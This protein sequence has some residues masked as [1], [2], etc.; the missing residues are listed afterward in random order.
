MI[1][2]TEQQELYSEEL[3]KHHSNL[4][5]ILEGHLLFKLLF[6]FPTNLINE[7]TGIYILTS[8]KFNRRDLDIAF[9][10]YSAKPEYYNDTTY[11][12]KIIEKFPESETVIDESKS[13]N[14]TD[15]IRRTKIKFVTEKEYIKDFGNFLAASDEQILIFTPFIKDEINNLLPKLK[16]KKIIFISDYQI[17]RTSSNKR[18]KI[19]DTNRYLKIKKNLKQMN[20]KIQVSPL[21]LIQARNFRVPDF[22]ENFKG[23]LIEKL[24][25]I[26]EENKT[27][28]HFFGEERY[29]AIRTIN[30]L[31]RSNLPL[32]YDL[33]RGVPQVVTPTSSVVLNNF[34]SLKDPIK[35]KDLYLRVKKISESLYIILNGL[36]KNYVEYFNHYEE[37]PLPERKDFREYISSIFI[38]LLLEK[39]KYN[40][41]NYKLFILIDQNLLDIVMPDSIDLETLDLITKNMI[42]VTE[43]ELLH[44]ADFWYA[45]EEDILSMN[46]KR[47]SES[48]EIF[49]PRQIK[50]ER[51]IEFWAIYG[52]DND[53]RLK[54]SEYLGVKYI[55]LIIEYWKKY[56]KGLDVYELRNKVLEYTDHLNI[57]SERKQEYKQNHSASID[58]YEKDRK[59]IRER[60]KALEK[61]PALKSFI[62]NHIKYANYSYSYDDLGKINCEIIDPDLPEL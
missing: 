16:S 55:C 45:I 22:L 5:S 35:Q 26:I 46:D 20:E 28:L 24:N 59:A 42:T 37:I 19:I 60:I 43:N 36:K 56:K 33:T 61:I 3:L 8:F 9:S 47:S 14:I 52:F 10:K 12:N 44:S 34:H 25:S 29:V 11:L 15:L 31:L 13:K 27:R 62:Q 51:Q 18:V 1:L 48:K 41:Q 21:N 39:R 23:G 53:I 40:G 50:F 4:F 32:Y 7:L 57:L 38:S 54:Y 49:I 2:I 58:I 30:Y 17:D 6:K